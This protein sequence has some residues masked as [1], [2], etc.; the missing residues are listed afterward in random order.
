MTDRGEEIRRLLRQCDEEQR[1][2]VL[3]FLRRDTPLHPLEAEWNVRAEVILEA[4]SRASDIT[5]RGVRGVIAEAAF[6]INVVRELKGWKQEPV[7][8]ESAYDFLLS[9]A[10]GSVRIQVKLQRREKS[11]P[12]MRRGRYVVETQRTRRGTTNT[13]EDSRP[14]RFGEFDILAVSLHP[15][16]NDWATFLYT[17]GA[18]LVPRPANPT[19]MEVQQLFPLPPDDNWTDDLVT[20]INWFRSGREKR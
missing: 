3:T 9:D 17:V 15:S 12:M 19:W 1:R 13:G 16:T 14:Y 5:R 2:D 8:D 4:I 6:E 18:W 10:R 20:C 7:P 11:K